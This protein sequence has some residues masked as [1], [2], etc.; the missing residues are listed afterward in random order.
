MVAKVLIIIPTVDKVM[1]EV[2][3]SIAS[4]DYPNFRLMVNVKKPKLSIKKK[5]KKCLENTLKNITIHRNELRE[6]AL[7]ID[8]DY[9]WML[10]SDV[11]P[12]KNALSSLMLQTGKK[13]STIASI[14]INGNFIPA[15]T[16]NP[17]KSIIG[18][19]Y[20]VK[21]TKKHEWACGK[22]VGDNMFYILREPQNSLIQVDMIGL[23][24]CL[25][26]RKVLEWIKLT[27]EEVFKI[28]TDRYG[29]KTLAGDCVAF[30]NI[31]YNMG[32]KLYMDGS[33]ICEHLIQEE[34]P[35]C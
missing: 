11:V 20:P 9:Y 22:W 5:S 27:E 34:K 28:S 10:D 1:P 25:V 30:G 33:V 15:G 8:A 2:I 17:E 12:P 16:V 4:Q 18:G 24:C 26:K 7:K 23:G 6:K 21:Y 3:D 19:W 29:R 32:Y 14:N 31:A 35:V 13:V